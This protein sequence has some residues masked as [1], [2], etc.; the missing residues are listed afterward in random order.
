VPEPEY[1]LAVLMLLAGASLYWA[2][3]YGAVL[4]VGKSDGD[5]RP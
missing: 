1:W 2:I 4:F 3:V 5:D